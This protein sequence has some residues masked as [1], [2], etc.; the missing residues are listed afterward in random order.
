MIRPYRYC[1]F[2]W[3]TREEW[4]DYQLNCAAGEAKGFLWL[5]F[6]EK[7]KETNKAFD[8]IEKSASLH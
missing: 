6:L 4:L 5:F 2:T 3:W 7:L 1:P 8:A